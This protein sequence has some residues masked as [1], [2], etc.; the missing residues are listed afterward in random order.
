M[1]ISFSCVC[2]FR[3]SILIKTTKIL[4]VF[5]I[6]LILFKLYKY[7]D[8][9]NF[10]NCILIYIIYNFLQKKCKTSYIVSNYIGTRMF[11]SFSGFFLQVIAE[12]QRRLIIVMVERPQSK[13]FFFLQI[14][15]QQ[16]VCKC[17]YHNIVNGQLLYGVP[18]LCFLYEML[19]S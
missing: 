9:E 3:R 1:H 16:G 14:P 4:K 17:V 13:D 19:D 5:Q 12:Q 10:N 11:S 6:K 15:F 18:A 7:E 2:Y 8:D